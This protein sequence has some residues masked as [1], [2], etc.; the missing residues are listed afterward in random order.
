MAPW[1]RGY[2]HPRFSR[3]MRTT[4]LEMISMTPGRPDERRVCVHF[5]AT[6]CRC[7]RRMVSGVTSDATS[8]KYMDIE[9]LKNVA[10]RVVSTG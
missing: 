6:S 8:L 7:Q 3:A 2:P 5:W 1:I 10:T 4:R 9:L